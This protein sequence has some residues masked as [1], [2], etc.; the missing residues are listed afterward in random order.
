M[1]LRFMLLRLMLLRLFYTR[2]CRKAFAA[3]AA[4]SPYHGRGAFP[5]GIHL[6]TVSRCKLM[7]IAYCEIL[8]GLSRRKRILNG[9]RIAR[10]VHMSV[11]IK[12]A[13][14]SVQFSGL[15]PVFG[16]AQP[17]CARHIRAVAP[18][19]GIDYA[20]LS[21]QSARSQVYHAPFCCR[22]PAPRPAAMF[23]YNSG[24]NPAGPALAMCLPLPGFRKS[25]ILSI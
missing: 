17:R 22:A 24:Q 16:A 9:I 25:G 8:Y 15:F 12:P 11:M 18:L 2:P 21:E 7:L 6:R 23:S 20:R 10:I 1:L 4:Y 5:A 19:S 13:G 3:V 14:Q